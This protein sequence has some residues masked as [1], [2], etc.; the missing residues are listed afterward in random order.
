MILNKQRYL[1]KGYR[2]LSNNN[3][4]KVMEKL[5]STDFFFCEKY[6]VST[7]NKQEIIGW[8][9]YITEICVQ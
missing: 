8:L 6:W 9:R 3:N 5:G 7:W 4:K 2:F 1:L